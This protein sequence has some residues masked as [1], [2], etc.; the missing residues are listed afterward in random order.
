MTQAT[1]GATTDV[2]AIVIV[3]DALRVNQ[4]DFKI[5]EKYIQME[6]LLLKKMW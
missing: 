2:D 1:D 4:E 6:L 5:I 3:L